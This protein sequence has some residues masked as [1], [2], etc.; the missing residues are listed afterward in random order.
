MVNAITITLADIIIFFK[1]IITSFFHIFPKS[2][3]LSRDKPCLS[4]ILTRLTDKIFRG[5]RVSSL[6]LFSPLFYEINSPSIDYRILV[7]V[8]HGTAGAA[9]DWIFMGVLRFW[10]LLKKRKKVTDRK[11][12]IIIAT[13]HGS[14]R[15]LSPKADKSKTE[16]S[17]IINVRRL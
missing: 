6:S 15:K 13:L 17:C 1:N 9:T 12:L 10:I 11:S 5:S 4:F 8:Y 3:I 16:I 2:I 14:H 7:K